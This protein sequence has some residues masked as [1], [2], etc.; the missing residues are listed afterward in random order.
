MPDVP[1]SRRNEP[2]SSYKSNSN[3]DPEINCSPHVQ[4]VF[5]RAMHIRSIPMWTGKSDNYAYL[6][7]DDTT[8]DAV[9]VDPAN[10]DE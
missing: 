1:N 9:I 6:I 4:L 3:P 7:T 2:V 10:P 8:R 5:A